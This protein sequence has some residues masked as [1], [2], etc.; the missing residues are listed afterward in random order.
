MSRKDVSLLFA[1]SIP[2]QCVGADPRP[3]VATIAHACAGCHATYG[4]SR[5]AIPAIN[6]KSVDEFVR[7]MR[8]FKSGK[9]SASVMNRIARGY[10]DED[11]IQLAVFFKAL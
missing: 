2:L 5:T 10:T 3:E 9:R 6:G 1:L 8:D 11:F 7:L 4:L